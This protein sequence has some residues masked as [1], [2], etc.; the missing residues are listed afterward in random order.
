METI[1][2]PKIFV[3]GGGISGLA[4]ALALQMQGFEVCVFERDNFFCDRRQ[5]FGMT[6]TNNK[7][8]PLAALGIL[9]ECIKISCPSNC[10]WVFNSE[11][12]V[13]GYFGRAFMKSSDTGP[14]DRGNLR[15]ARQ[16]LRKMLLDRLVPGTVKWGHKLLSYNELED[17]I[18]VSFQTNSETLSPSTTE[19]AS[20]EVELRCDLIVGADGIYSRVRQLRDMK[21]FH[22]PRSP[23]IYVGVSVIIGLSSAQHPLINDCGFYVLDGVHRLFVMPFRSTSNS[24]GESIT[25]TARSGTDDGT[26]E[27]T[28]EGKGVTSLTMWQ[29]SFSG[30]AESEA[31]TMRSK[32]PETLRSEALRRCQHWFDPVTALIKETDAGEIWGTALYDRNP[33]EQFPKNTRKRKVITSN[34]SGNGDDVVEVEL[35]PWAGNRVTLVGDG[36]H[37]MTMFKGQGCNQALADGPLL[38]QWLRRPNLTVDNVSTRL[39]CFEREMIQRAGPKVAASREAACMLHSAAALVET[40]PVEGLEE[41]QAEVL[42]GL[43][44]RGVGA[45]LGGSLEAAVKDMVAE[46]D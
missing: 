20:C 16:D 24:S 44:R 35:A 25:P 23:L 21:C 31:E 46:L 3:I 19:A 33:M 38:A 22:I 7:K 2:S 18:L 12:N 8:G 34:P 27:S 26:T 4:C 10:H 30:L 37:P 17:G 13:I 11:G 5:G 42:A 28:E 45:H 9:D 41:R 29:L 36:C 6:L 39:R 15:I 32:D 40:F 43:R 14:C 1:F